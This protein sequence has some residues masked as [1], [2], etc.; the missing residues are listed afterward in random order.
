MRS[1]HIQV[2][3]ITSF[4]SPKEPCSLL[5]T[6]F[7]PVVTDTAWESTSWQML[8]LRRAQNIKQQRLLMADTTTKGTAYLGHLYSAGKWFRH[9]SWRYFKN[10]YVPL[11]DMVELGC[12]ELTFGAHDLKGL[13][14]LK[15]ILCFMCIVTLHRKLSKP[16]GLIPPYFVISKT[17]ACAP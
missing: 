1:I 15:K 8:H 14:Q 5:R 13:F 10:V 17:Q 3:N 2:G 16:T 9:H 6:L 12:A 11:G 4:L 7:Y